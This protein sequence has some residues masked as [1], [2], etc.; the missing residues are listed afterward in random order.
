[1][2]GTLLK[3]V[4]LSL[5]AT[6]LA[7]Q[8]ADSLIAKYIQALGGMQR[9]QAIQSLR[10][11]GKYTGSGG[12]QAAVVQENKRPNR[13][14]EE[15]S[16]QGMTGINAYDGHDGW[17]IE[18]WQGKR[19]PESLGEEEMHS[20][21]D[22]ADFDGPLVNYQ[23]KGNRVE[24]Q[25]LEPIEGSDAYKLKVTRPNGDI[26]FVY[27]DAEYYVPIR[28][29]IQWMIRGAPT[30]IEISLG[31]YKQVAGVYLPFSYEVGAKGGSS[32]DRGKTTY[33]KIEAN[34]PL[35]DQ[36]FIRPGTHP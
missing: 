4:V 20:I 35:D 36:R 15:F 19:D 7:A 32:S 30:E 22:D 12:F 5:C 11:T 16:L 1:M 17:K 21:L 10:R 31:D 13:V 2:R 23:A 3:A 8:S 9:I 14:R 34:V 33:D 28:I 29:D 6:P 25:G 18:P 24:F 27:L 26:N